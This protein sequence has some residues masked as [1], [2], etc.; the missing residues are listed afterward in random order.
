MY[1]CPKKTT[2]FISEFFMDFFGSMYVL[3]NYN[4]Y[5]Y[6][7]CLLFFTWYFGISIFLCYCKKLHSCRVLLHHLKRPVYV[8]IFYTSILSL[9]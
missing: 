2:I 5:L 6:M 8:I 4:N 1:H 9:F 3:C 7:I